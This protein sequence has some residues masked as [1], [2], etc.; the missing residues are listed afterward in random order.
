MFSPLGGQLLWEADQVP[1]LPWGSALQI[2]SSMCIQPSMTSSPGD[3]S[4]MW[5]G[6]RRPFLQS[7]G[8][9]QSWVFAAWEQ[10]VDKCLAPEHGL[11]SNTGTAAA[12]QSPGAKTAESSQ[13]ALQNPNLTSVSLDSVWWTALHTGDFTSGPQDV[14]I[15]VEE[16]DSVWVYLFLQ[17]CFFLTRLKGSGPGRL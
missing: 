3:T 17:S 13:L 9:W 11:G 16:K 7:Q 10:R 14:F 8:C 12:Q 2:I 1:C 6:R 4:H 5:D 15:W